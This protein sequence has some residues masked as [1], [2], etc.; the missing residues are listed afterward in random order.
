MKVS[1]SINFANG[2]VNKVIILF[3][4]S[5]LFHPSLERKAELGR[6][7]G[8]AAAG[9]AGE[10]PAGHRHEVAIRQED[11]THKVARKER[12]RGDAATLTWTRQS[13]WLAA[14][15]PRRSRPFTLP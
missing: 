15:A 13:D 12:K 4:D 7:D 2:R 9:V 5:L 1:I 3:T 6:D 8:R 11:R 10:K 14:R